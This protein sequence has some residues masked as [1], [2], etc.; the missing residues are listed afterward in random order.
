MQ[1][2]IWQKERWPRFTWQ[3]DAL[4]PLVSQARLAQGKL[5]AKVHDM[6]FELSREA[7][8]D[9][10]TEE[11]IKT[12]EIEG[13]VLNRDSVR[14]S[15]AK[16]LGLSTFGLPEPDRAYA[17][18]EIGVLCRPCPTRTHLAHAARYRSVASSAPVRLGS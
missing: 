6:G 16:H 9:V 8:A 12:S 4:L 13:E 11:A 7:S 14:S 18:A 2:W 15:V 3:A 5:L 10:L 1:K 17:T